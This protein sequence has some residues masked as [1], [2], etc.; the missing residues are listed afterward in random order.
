M[1]RTHQAGFSR[2]SLGGVG[3][4]ESVRCHEFGLVLLTNGG[5]QQQHQQI[6]LRGMNKY[7]KYQTLN[8]MFEKVSVLPDSP[9]VSHRKN[10]L[11]FISG[12]Q[13]VETL[14]LEGV[15]VN[16]IPYCY[17]RGIKVHAQQNGL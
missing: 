3:F 10:S 1:P 15:F 11:Q 14:E 13:I 2:R 7:G 5:V 16:L 8:E 4:F 17:R 6:S 9:T 12:L